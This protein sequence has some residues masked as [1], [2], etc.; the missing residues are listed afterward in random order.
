MSRSSVRCQR[1]RRSATRRPPTTQGRPASGA[2]SLAA[3]LAWN[4]KL[5]TSRGRDRRKAPASARTARIGRPR[6]TPRHS[7]AIPAVAE[8][9]R[10]GPFPAQGDD[11]GAPAAAVEARRQGDQRP[12]GP[13]DVEVGDHQG[14]RHRLGPARGLGGR[15]RVVGR[16][17]ATDHFRFGFGF[18]PA[19]EGL[20]LPAEAFDLRLGLAEGRVLL[21]DRRVSR[22]DA[23]S[24]A[25]IAASFS[26]RGLGDLASDRRPSP[27]LR[28][29]RSVPAG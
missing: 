25:W 18:G 17:L 12:L 19:P 21:L 23:A 9:P 22:L 1:L 24:V 6:S 4:R 16:G 15:S 27:R 3:T 29:P 26:D 5:W 14:D 8:R 11:R 7:T 13:A 20:Q 10:Q 2:A 28:G